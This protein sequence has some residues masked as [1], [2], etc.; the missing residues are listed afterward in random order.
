MSRLAIIS[1]SSQ[2]T[3]EA[4]RQLGALLAGGN[5]I[6]LHG[7][8]GSGKTCFTR[9]VVAAAAPESAHLVSS[10]TFAIMNE[11]PGAIPVYHFDFYRL[12]NGHEIV[13]LGFEEY[14]HG[15]GICIAEWSERLGELLPP[16]HLSVNF[17]YTG[18]D[19]RNISFEATGTE[20][21]GLLSR[22]AKLE[23]FVIFPLT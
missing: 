7:E 6:A 17:E 10:P 12:N 22:F 18:D 15:N 20:T 23:K 21:E 5:F 13:E 11:Y 9:G 1:G 2:E 3:E 14:L 16:D 8:L 4:G 19:Q